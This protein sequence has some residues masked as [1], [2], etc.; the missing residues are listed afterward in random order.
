[1]MKKRYVI[2]TLV[3]VVLLVL[4]G[5][6]GINLLPDMLL[7]AQPESFKLTKS[8]VI[9]VLGTPAN[10]V[11]EPS[12]VMKERVDEAVKLWKEGYSKNIIFSG[13]SA[14]NKFV[15][16]EVMAKYARAH[17]VT[18][19]G[20]FIE[21]QAQNTYQNAYNSVEIMKQHGWKSAIVVS[22][23]A[24][25]RRANFIFSHYRIQYC[26]DAC[27]NAPEQSTWSI[28][29]FDQREKLHFLALY[30]SGRSLTY[31]LTPE[32]AAKMEQ[33][34]TKAAPIDTPATTAN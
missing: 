1:M 19:S 11:G 13:S 30:F 6:A 25:L 34:L 21:P 14:H 20:I 26:M 9:I 7:G 27:K 23:A 32:Q 31:G 22:S 17:G 24:H 3:I 12:P 15:E 10:K 5:V 28:F 33:G 18:D 8:D 2:R 29:R 16:A 4:I